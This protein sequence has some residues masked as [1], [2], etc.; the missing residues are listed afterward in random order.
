MGPNCPGI[1][2]PRG[3]KIGIMPGHIHTPGKIGELGSRLRRRGGNRNSSHSMESGICDSEQ[4][5][6]LGLMISYDRIGL[7]KEL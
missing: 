4:R 1:I 7:E 5:G 2:D 6:K 3:C